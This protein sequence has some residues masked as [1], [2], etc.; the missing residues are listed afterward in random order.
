MNADHPPIPAWLSGRPLAGGLVVP[1]ITPQL[2]D[3]R[4]LFGSIEQTSSEHALIH[5][6]CGVC[7]R[8]IAPQPLVLL[9]RMSDIPR[10]C[11]NEP[12]L[13]PQCAAYTAVACPMI[14]GTLKTYRSTQPPGVPLTEDSAARR[15]SPAEPWFAVWVSDYDLV[16]DH[17]NLCASYR[18]IRTR[19]IRPITWSSQ[20]LTP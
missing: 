18:R 14:N 12:A 10:Q 8:R 2:P 1:W 9:L 20:R 11:T 19:R 4:H 13:H 6:L 5:R 16:I 7:G 3:G 17:G 15:G